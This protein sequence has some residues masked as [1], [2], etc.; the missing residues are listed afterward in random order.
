MGF[1]WLAG[2]MLLMQPSATADSFIIEIDGQPVAVAQKADYHFPLLG[3]PFVD[4]EKLDGFLAWVA[5]RVNRQ[6]IN[7]RIDDSGRIIAEENGRQL[8]V[9]RLKHDF[10]QYY[11][12]T[13]G[14]LVQN[15]YRTLLPKVDRKLLAQ[16]RQKQIGWYVTYF[17]AR[18]RN[19]SHNISLAAQAINNWVLLPGEVFSFNKVV[20]QRTAQKGYRP[21]PVIVRGELSEG[22]GGGICQ[23]SSTLFNAVDRAGMHILKRY[24]H[25]REVPYVPPGRDAT[26]S[27]YGP[28][29]VFQ[30]LYPYPVL[31]RAYARYGQVMVSVH[32]F[33]E[34]EYEPRHV[35]GAS[36]KLPQETNANEQKVTESG[37]S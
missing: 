6:P 36:T 15:P 27:W 3:K 34:L 37:D 31:I 26:V 25:S 29:F 16:V 18:N 17:N 11:Y 19:R 30:N 14:M 8:D 20:G 10:L 9:E 35:P 28:D 1:A 32:S 22:I 13:G 33:Q 12:G 2:L 24:S 21:A 23:V 4:D 5:S 7:A